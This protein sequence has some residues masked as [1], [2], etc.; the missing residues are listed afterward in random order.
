MNYTLNFIKVITQVAVVAVSTFI[1][2]ALLHAAIMF[3]FHHYFMDIMSG[4]YQFGMGFV[5]VIVT[6]LYIV[7]YSM[8]MEERAERKRAEQIKA[9]TKF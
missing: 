5:T 4:D 1:I 8:E 3:N 2:P 9:L 6:L 7:T